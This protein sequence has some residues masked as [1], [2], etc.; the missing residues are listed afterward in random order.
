MLGLDAALCVVQ[1]ELAVIY[2]VASEF[3][4]PVATKD[5]NKCQVVKDEINCENPETIM[6]EFRA[7]KSG[8]FSTKE[9]AYYGSFSLSYYSFGSW[10]K[11]N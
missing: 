1:T 8:V 11:Q 2:L 5:Q 4:N 6:V 3:P 10:D 9:G 7:V